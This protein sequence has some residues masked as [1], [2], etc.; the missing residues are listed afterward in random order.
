MTVHDQLWA[1]V[2][3]VCDPN[4]IDIEGVFSR[5]KAPK[6]AQARQRCMR[7]TKAETTLT[8]AQ[9]GRFFK[10]DH[11]TVMYALK[12]TD[13][14]FDELP[15]LPLKKPP[16]RIVIPQFA[17][18]PPPPRPR[19]LPSPLD[20]RR[21]TIAERLRYSERRSVA[22]VLYIH[23]AEYGSRPFAHFHWWLREGCRRETASP[24]GQTHD[25]PSSGDADT[26]E[27]HKSPPCA[28][29]VKHMEERKCGES[30]ANAC[31][32]R[33]SIMETE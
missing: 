28:D 30:Y 12:L 2:H 27:R 32:N 5:S 8:L 17:R 9:I 22:R 19:Y 18:S 6:H 26:H 14:P 7:A 4:G 11:S 33:A 20:R 1:I 10:R 24:L 3:S 16:G 21:M 25:Y 31:T 23:Q 13:I 15:P 29:A